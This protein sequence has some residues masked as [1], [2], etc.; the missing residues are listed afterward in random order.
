MWS[1]TNSWAYILLL[2]GKKRYPVTLSPIML[3]ECDNYRALVSSERNR[4]RLSTTCIMTENID[5]EF[6]WFLQKCGIKRRL[7]RRLTIRSNMVLP[8]DETKHFNRSRSSTRKLKGRTL[9]KACFAG[10]LSVSGFKTFWSDVFIMDHHHH[11]LHAIHFSSV[12]K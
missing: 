8:K 3:C 4:A 1:N 9:Y 6:D 2:H 5:K 11:H 10:P 12:Y 7:R